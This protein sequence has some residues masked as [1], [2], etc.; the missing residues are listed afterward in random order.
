MTG[1]RETTPDDVPQ[2]AGRIEEK[3]RGMTGA[4]LREIQ[5]TVPGGAVMGNCMALVDSVGDLLIQAAWKA[6]ENDW[7]RSAINLLGLY[8]G[9]E[10]GARLNLRVILHYLREKELS[11]TPLTHADMAILIAHLNTTHPGEIDTYAEALP[12]FLSEAGALGA[13]LAAELASD[14]EPDSWTPNSCS[15]PR[16]TKP[17][18]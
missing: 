9:A 11:G 2:G 3:L 16:R 18:G 15:I 14:V 1:I 6:G 5:E 8:P 17:R 10:G 12:G 4:G 13:K 7:T